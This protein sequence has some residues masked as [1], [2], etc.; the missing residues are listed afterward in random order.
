MPSSVSA[1]V[2][3]RSSNRARSVIP[4]RRRPG[5]VLEAVGEA[6]VEAHLVGPDRGHPGVG[7]GRRRGSRRAGRRRTAT[8]ISARYSTAAIV[9][10]RP[11]KLRGAGL[12]PVVGRP[13]L[14]RRQRVEDV[15]PAVEDAARAARRTCRSSRRGSRCRRPGRRSA[16]AAPRG[17]RRRTSRRPRRG[18][19]RTISATGLIVPTAFDAQPTA[20][21][22]GLSGE[23]RRRAPRGRACS[24][25]AADADGPDREAAVARPLASHGP[26]LPSWSRLVTTISSPGAIVA[27]IER[28]TWNVSVVM[29]APNL[30][31][32]GR[33]RAEHVGHRLVGLGDDRVA[34]PARQ[35]RAVVVRVR[36]RGSSA[37]PRR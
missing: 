23:E 29:F 28:L 13:E 3:V 4:Y 37:R 9:P 27:T 20:T 33:R 1:A 26:T 22:C 11:S 36:R 24:R 2:G 15:G 7:R 14:V 19:A 10:A 32:S 34:P 35:E 8:P 31:S 16:G 30:I 25:R 6:A 21:S 12:E 18:P 5:I 17:P